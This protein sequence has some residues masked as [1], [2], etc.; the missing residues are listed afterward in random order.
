MDI[1]KERIIKKIKDILLEEENIIFAYVHG[2]F[3]SLSEFNDIDIAV[4]LKLQGT[5]HFD[6]VDFE[7]SL[8]LKIEKII[9]VPVDIRTLNYAPLPFKYQASCG[10]LIFSFDEL[11]REEFLCR[12]WQ[13]YFDSLPL[14][15]MYLKDVLNAKV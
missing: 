5:V 13:K 7:I 1:K 2:S 12:T 11:K 10:L 4:Y 9:K 6:I 8:S 14:Y 3:T 15:R